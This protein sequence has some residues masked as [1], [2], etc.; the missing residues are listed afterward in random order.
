VSKNFIRGDPAVEVSSQKFGPSGTSV[1]RYVGVPEETVNV[2]VL[3]MFTVLESALFPVSF[4]V[5]LIT[6]NTGVLVS[7]YV[8]PLLSASVTTTRY[9]NWFPVVAVSGGTHENDAFAAPVPC[10]MRE[11]VPLMPVVEDSHLKVRVIETVA[12]SAATLTV[13]VSVIPTL[14]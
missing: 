13:K 9:K 8:R 11:K 14:R 7:V 3:L 1:Y 2:S 5:P 4:N 12:L 10:F 6:A